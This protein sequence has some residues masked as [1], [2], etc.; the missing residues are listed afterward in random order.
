MRNLDS[1]PVY[2]NLLRIQQPVTARLS[3]GHRISGVILFLALP[4]GLWLFERSLSGPAGYA[5]VR[6]MLASP[7]AIGAMLVVA[8]MFVLHFLAGI[9]F[10]LMD[11]DFGV[12]LP[13]ARR[14]ARAALWAAPI[15]TMALA[16]LFLW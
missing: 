6:E 3:I 11:V 8:W 5:A 9:R 4:A 14:S 1:R 15:V 13:A 10:L 16:V 2:L 7:F 12:E